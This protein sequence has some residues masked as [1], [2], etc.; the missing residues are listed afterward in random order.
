[1]K[2]SA[3]RSDPLCTPVDDQS[4]TTIQIVSN[5]G[6]YTRRPAASSS[7]PAPP[8]P[9]QG[10]LPFGTLFVSLVNKQGALLFNATFTV[11]CI[12]Y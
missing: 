7:A 9:G 2:M 1:M 4:P 8:A 3:G 5:T 11:H 6:N 12:P 10:L